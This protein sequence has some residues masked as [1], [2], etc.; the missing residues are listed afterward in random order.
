MGSAGRAGSKSLEASIVLRLFPNQLSA[1]TCQAQG[2]ACEF[3][4]RRYL[5]GEVVNYSPNHLDI[6]SSHLPW[7]YVRT[8]LSKRDPVVLG[9][10]LESIL[11]SIPLEETTSFRGSSTLHHLTKSVS[12]LK[13]KLQSCLKTEPQPSSAQPRKSDSKAQ[14]PPSQY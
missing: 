6:P 14:S 3:V 10:I 11:K 5:E 9:S 4:Q 2:C 12:F 7:L 8:Q 13:S 1:G